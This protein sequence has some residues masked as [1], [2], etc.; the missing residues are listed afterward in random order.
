[1]NPDFWRREE[2]PEWGVRK[3]KSFELSDDDATRSIG[4]RVGD[5]IGSGIVGL[6]GD[7]GA[8]KTTFMQGFVTAFEIDPREVSSPT[9]SLVNE[10]SGSKTIYHLDLYRLENTDDLESIGY[11]DYLDYGGI[12]CIEWINK[13]PESWQGKGDIIVILHKGEARELIWFRSI[14]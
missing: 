3:Y 1:M 12:L 8:G 10:Y 9:Y 14:L 6:I 13:L 2:I 11:W 7:L 5:E 4:K